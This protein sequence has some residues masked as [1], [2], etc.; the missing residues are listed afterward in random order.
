ML[1][2]TGRQNRLILIATWIAALDCLAVAR[3]PQGTIWSNLSFFFL[4]GF[5]QT[6]LMY[7]LLQIHI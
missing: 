6:L 5:S 1:Q 4:G 2:S 7:L 3:L